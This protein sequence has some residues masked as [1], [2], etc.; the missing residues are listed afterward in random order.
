MTGAAAAGDGW[1]SPAGQP[2]DEFLAARLDEDEAAAK[3]TEHNDGPHTLEWKHGGG[4]HLTF[5]NG[6]SEDY[7]A[8]FAGDWDRILIARDSV[9]GAPLA[10]HIARHDPARVLREAGAKRAILE[11]FQ[12]S[13]HTLEW[14]KARQRTRPIG[15]TDIADTERELDIL[16]P[17]IE[18]LA[19]AYIAGES[20]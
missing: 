8:V 1:C 12:E 15:D 17:V 20:R 3:A 10:A 13:R 4:R 6:R 7:E 2:W 18:S 9:R 19:A 5:D 11:S 14:L 16:R